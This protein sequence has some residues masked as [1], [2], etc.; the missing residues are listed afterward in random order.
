MT[1]KFA[2]WRKSLRSSDSG[3]CVEVGS[4]P[5][6][7]GVRDTKDRRSGTLAVSRESWARFVAAVKVGRFGG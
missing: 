1:E 6:M 3:N 5:G 2:N 7:V 4:V